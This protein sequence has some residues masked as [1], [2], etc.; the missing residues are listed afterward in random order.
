M[1]SADDAHRRSIHDRLM[2]CA[3]N[4][5][6]PGQLVALLGMLRHVL[7]LGQ[8]PAV[9]PAIRAAVEKIEGSA[10]IRPAPGAPALFVFGDSH[11]FAMFNGH[12]RIHVIYYYACTMHAIG[13]DGLDFLRLEHHGVEDGDEVVLLFGE[14]DA[15]IHIARQR[16][17]HGRA[18]DEVI[19][20]LV[21]AYVAALDAKV[22][23]Y[24]QLGVTVA[25]VLPPSNDPRLVADPQ[26][27]PTGSIEDRVRFTQQLNRRLRAAVEPRGYRFLDLNSL[28]AAPDGTLPGAITS[29][30]L[31]IGASSSALAIRVVS[32]LTRQ[33]L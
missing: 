24:R 28:Y 8:D 31:H 29:D 20:T 32:A 13:R 9:M 10:V 16:D 30:G 23:S 22:A 27:A 15:R 14:I 2:Y 1:T 17:N 6:S 3:N 25:A 7:A 18:P 11:A 33:R 4:L 26:L 19:A 21:D 5:T 12:P